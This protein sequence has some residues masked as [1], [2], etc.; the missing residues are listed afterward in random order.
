[1]IGKNVAEIG[2][3]SSGLKARAFS[4]TLNDGTILTESL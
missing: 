4:L 2:E 1:M 3:I